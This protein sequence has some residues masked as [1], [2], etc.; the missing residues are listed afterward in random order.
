MGGQKKERLLYDRAVRPNPACVVRCG[1]GG[2][3]GVRVNGGLRVPTKTKLV[4]LLARSGFQ[5]AAAP[6]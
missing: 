1:G 6:V 3:G 4:V 5:T 2:G